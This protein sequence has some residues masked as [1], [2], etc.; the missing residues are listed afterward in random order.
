MQQD[1]MTGG[2]RSMWAVYEFNS[3]GGQIMYIDLA[4]VVG[5]VIVVVQFAVMMALHGH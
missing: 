2:L 3:R 4:T 5:M 1:L